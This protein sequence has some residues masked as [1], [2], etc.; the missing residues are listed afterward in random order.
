MPIV[1]FQLPPIQEPFDEGDVRGMNVGRR[2]LR[3]E[4][5][6][7]LHKPESAGKEWCLILPFPNTY[8]NAF[9][10]MCDTDVTTHHAP[11]GR[12][13]LYL[14][15]FGPE[16]EPPVEVTQ[17]IHKVGQY[18][19]M[20]DFLA[21]SFALDYDREGG[22][23]TRPQT[24]IGTLRAQAKPY[25]SQKATK[26]TIAA[27][28][29][30]VARSIAFLGEMTCYQSADCVIAMPPSDPTKEYNL[31]RHL[32]AQISAS[33]RLE[34][35]TPHLR[36]ITPRNSIKGVQV[37]EKLDTLRG[38]IQA[39]GGVFDKRRVLL[40][41]D[42]YQSG[43]SMNYC[44]WLLLQAGAQK[45]FGLACEKTCRNDDNVRGRI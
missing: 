8:Q 19:A 43:T 33:S 1:R 13:C 11:N 45:I 25:G 31:P 23:P 30:L 10:C 29:Q 12:L 16:E 27:A 7:P 40:I 26:Q 42:L 34:D 28:N 4:W 37:A 21:L 35:L 38:T 20:K 22:N 36:T 15:G 9:S 24:D 5:Q 3:T 44:A 18:V 39:D 41:D 17:W 14:R 32:A 2:Q 6:T